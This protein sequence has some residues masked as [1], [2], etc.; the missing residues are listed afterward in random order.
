MFSYISYVF[1]SFLYSKNNNNKFDFCISIAPLPPGIVGAL[2]QKL[3]KLPHHFDVP[4]I[5]PDLGIA[6][7]MIKNKLL[8][9]LLYK[10]EIFVYNNSKSI[11]AIT[12]GQIENIRKKGVDRS[13]IK[14]IPD[15]IDSKYFIK[16]IKD[17]NAMVK[18]NI[19][20]KYGN[21]KIISFIGN[22]GALQNP[23]IF[24]RM[25]ENIARKKDDIMLLFIGDGIMLSSL[26][27]EVKKIGL[28]NVDF[29]GRLPR[30]LIPSYMNVSD[31]LIANFLSNKYMDICIPGK[32]YEYLMSKTPIVMGAKG[33]AANFIDKHNAGIVVPP[34]DA[35]AFTEAIYKI[36]DEKFV[37]NPNYGEFIED[38]SLTKIAKSYESVF[39]SLLLD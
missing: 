1:S 9:K 19:K 10:L 2:S 5:L 18:E 37:Y 14:Y 39:K 16:N 34:S 36:I 21:K 3:F 30:E 11:S 25:M 13:K 32:L 6:S 33:E 8:I 12:H 28:L 29:V 20:N 15:W 17:N 4:D 24:I 38:F 35:N 22:I 31:V 26:K 27:K 23:I 7:G